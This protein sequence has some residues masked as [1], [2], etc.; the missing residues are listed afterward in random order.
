MGGGLGLLRTE[1]GQGLGL[2]G[3]SDAEVE[4]GV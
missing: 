3:V 4:V 2:A 1:G